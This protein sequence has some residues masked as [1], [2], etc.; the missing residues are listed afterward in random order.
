M[1]MCDLVCFLLCYVAVLNKECTRKKRR[2]IDFKQTKYRTLTSIRV[3]SAKYPLLEKHLFEDAS[4][5]KIDFKATYK[6]FN[7]KPSRQR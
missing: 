3:P 7:M 4:S 2:K 1:D 6:S 5:Q